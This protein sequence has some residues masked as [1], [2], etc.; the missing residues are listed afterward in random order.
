VAKKRLSSAKQFLTEKNRESFLDEMF[1]ALWGFV[2][3]KLQIPVSELSKENVSNVLES[4]KVSAETVQQFIKTFDNCEMAR[5]A[6]GAAAS[7]DEIYKSGIE[8]IS[9]LESEIR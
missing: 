3:D 1:R 6:P 5:F 4:R 9:R 2:S 8:V 7:I